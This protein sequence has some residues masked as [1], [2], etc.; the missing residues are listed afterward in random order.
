VNRLRFLLLAILA[1]TFHSALV[2]E[3]ARAERTNFPQKARERFEK[4][5]ELQ[6]QGKL[7]EAIAAYEEAIRLGM[8]DFP[9]AHLYRANSNLDLKKYDTAIAQYT[10]F[11]KQFTLESSCRY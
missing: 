3:T 2:W 1:V 5:Q 7:E 6:D 9:R 11:L 10:A 4:G 8:K